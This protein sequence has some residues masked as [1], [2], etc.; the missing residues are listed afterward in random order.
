MKIEKKFQPCLVKI[1]ND[2]TQ[3]LE[4]HSRFEMDEVELL[5]EQ[6]SLRLHVNS[7]ICNFI[8]FLLCG[9]DDNGSVP[10]P[11]TIEHGEGDEREGDEDESQCGDNSVR[12]ENHHE[13]G[14]SFFVVVRE[15]IE[16]EQM[17]YVALD[18]QGCNLSNNQYKRFI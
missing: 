7:P 2:V 12:V 18:G 8:P 13:E 1:D 16:R 3:M 9:N 5:V 17:R 14:C 11:L 15:T 10:N 6:I 4:M